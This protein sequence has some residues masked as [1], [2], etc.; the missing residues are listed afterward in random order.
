MA[1]RML[2]TCTVERRSGSRGDVH[3]PCGQQCWLAKC[4]MHELW[5]KEVTPIMVY[6]GCQDA[7][8]THYEEEWWQQGCYV[9]ALWTGVVVTRM[10]HTHTLWTGVVGAKNAMRKHCGMR[11]WPQACCTQALWTAVVAVRMPYT[12]TREEW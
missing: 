7:I 4:G 9:Y 8:C 10:L 2:F 1:A 6:C 3:M 12:C 11:W 5:R